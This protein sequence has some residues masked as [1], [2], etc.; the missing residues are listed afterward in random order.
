MSE[1]KAVDEIQK[2]SLSPL[3]LLVVED[4]KGVQNQLKWALTEKY[5]VFMAEDRQTAL[6]IMAAEN[7]MVV[8]LDL[9]LPPDANGATEGLF[10]LEAIRE[11]YPATKVIIASG[12]SDLQNALKAIELGAYDFYSKPIDLDVLNHIIQ[13]AWHVAKL[14]KENERRAKASMENIYLNGIISGDPAMSKIAQSV[15][16]IAG[17]DISVLITGESGTGKELVAKAIHYDS[18]RASHEFVAINCAAI[19]ENLLESELFGF[20]KGSFTGAVSQSIGKVEMANQGTLFLDEIGDMPLILQSKL[21]RFLQER[22]IERIGGRKKIPIDI[23]VLCATHQNLKEMI[24]AG[25]FREDLYYRLNEF[26]I[27]LPPLRERLGDI[28][29]LAKYFI[30]RFAK[31]LKKQVT[32]ISDK[33]LMVLQDYEWPGNI[34][35]FENKMKRAVIMTEKKQITAQDLELTSVMNMD[36]LPTLKDFRDRHEKELLM[37]ALQATRGNVSLASKILDVSRPKIYEMIETYN[38]EL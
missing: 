13:R 8:I 11:K 4:D 29:L 38:I 28:E 23:R 18:P 24:S 25:T 15:R 27:S 6:D 17:T 31:D 19:P 2:G 12:N 20:E 36:Q 37:K 5:H 1:V 16:K 3:S 14:E 33:A 30:H 34:R 32:G 21:L 35:E 7:P 26:S 22:H 9:G 10:L